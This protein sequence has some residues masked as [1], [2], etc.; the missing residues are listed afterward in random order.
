MAS[1]G[2]SSNRN[3]P[4]YNNE[5]YY[6]RSYK[7][8]SAQM[9]AR[10]LRHEDYNTDTDANMFAGRAGA[11]CDVPMLSPEFMSALSRHVVQSR[12]MEHYSASDWYTRMLV[13]PR[14]VSNQL[15]NSSKVG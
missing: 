1:Y 13:Q 10:E 2:A 4:F 3:E 15:I 8:E 9:P 14:N 7:E 6:G 11:M 12:A 5:Q